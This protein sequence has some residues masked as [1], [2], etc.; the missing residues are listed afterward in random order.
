[1][2]KNTFK[3][4]LDKKELS[5]IKKRMFGKN[6]EL[7]SYP[8]GNGP[9]ILEFEK[10]F[11]KFIGVKYAITTTSGSTALT[12]SLA[13]LDLPE[14]SEILVPGMS[15]IATANAV[16]NLKFKIKFID[17]DENFNIDPLDVEKKISRNTKAIIVVHLYG[18][19]ANMDSINKIARNHKLTI[20]EDACQSHG[21]TYKGKKTG[22]IGDLGCFSFYTT[23]NMTTGEGG[24]ITTNSEKL[25][26]KIKLLRSHG[27][28]NTTNN[29]TFSGAGY[30]FAMTTMQ[31]ILGIVQLTKIAKLNF[32]RKKI[33]DIYRKNLSN[34]NLILPKE[35]I[36][37]D[38]SSACHLF[39]I[40]FTEKLSENYSAIVKNIK[41]E[42]I[43][44]SITYPEPMFMAPHFKISY[45]GDCPMSEKYCKSIITLFTDFNISPKQAYTISKKI[46]NI[47]KKY[48]K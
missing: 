7:P 34:L 44:F 22:S 8:F 46:A 35:S 24:M 25:A 30:N 3:S 13:S 11:A 36:T 47:I 20:I 31:A 23:K 10:K 17:V 38:T 1:M 5:E 42:G 33:Y 18:R 29:Y 16:Y 28:V 21:A 48:V 6:P 43:P 45:L 26:N 19:P 2:T 39:P 27:Y 37:K 14:D 32:C 15:F 12:L 9:S 4:P 41:R 40:L